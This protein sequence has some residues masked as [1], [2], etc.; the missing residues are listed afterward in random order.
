[1]TVAQV[2][3]LSESPLL[4]KIAI[5]KNVIDEGNLSNMAFNVPPIDLLKISV[6]LL[7]LVLFYIMARDCCW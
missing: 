7:L 6:K 5:L 1:M 2:D 3:S 4:E